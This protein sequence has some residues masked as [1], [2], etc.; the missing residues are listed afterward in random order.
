MVLSAV[1]SFEDEDDGLVVP[2][3]AEFVG[4]LV[5]SIDV[6]LP[7]FLKAFDFSPLHTGCATEHE[8]VSTVKGTRS[9]SCEPR[10]SGQEIT[11]MSCT[12]YPLA[13]WAGR[14]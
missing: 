6:D 13:C 8:S 14:S 7:V 9:S 4:A 3:L 12:T 10:N 2:S 11:E 5:A 1:L